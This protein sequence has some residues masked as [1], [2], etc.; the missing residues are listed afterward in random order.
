MF[1]RARGMYSGSLNTL[2]PFDVYC[3]IIWVSITWKI[4]YCGWI[5]VA[6][7]YHIFIYIHIKFLY[8]CVSQL[9]HSSEY[10]LVCN[11]HLGFA[12]VSIANLYLVGRGGIVSVSTSSKHWNTKFSVPIT[13]ELSP[14]W[15]AIRS[16]G[17]NWLNFH[18]HMQCSNPSVEMRTVKILKAYQ[19][20]IIGCRYRIT[21]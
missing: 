1:M 8:C 16:T 5:T 17:T 14:S 3:S 12:S 11:R 2:I 13:L 20:T 21:W 10:Y 6:S 4:D 15:P 19:H 18:Y 9:D 7:T